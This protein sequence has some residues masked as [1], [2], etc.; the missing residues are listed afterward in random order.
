MY[1]SSTREK[2]AVSEAT[3]PAELRERLQVPATP[4]SS[5]NE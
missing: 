1:A 4:L 5:V 2:Y 3:R